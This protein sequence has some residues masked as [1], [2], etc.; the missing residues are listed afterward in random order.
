[1]KHLSNHYLP[2]RAGDEVR[3]WWDPE[4]KDRVEGTARLVRP[5][6]GP[7]SDGWEIWFVRF[8]GHADAEERIVHPADVVVEIFSEAELDQEAQGVEGKEAPHAS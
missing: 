1:M 4:T 7:D 5:S 8:P 6:H 2:L 3:V